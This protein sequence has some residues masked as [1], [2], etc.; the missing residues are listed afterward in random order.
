[1][2]NLLLCWALLAVADAGVGVIRKFNHITFINL[3]NR[4]RW[5]N[6][7]VYCCCPCR[8]MR[9]RTGGEDYLSRRCT[10]WAQ[11]Q[12]HGI[13]HG[14]VWCRS[15]FLIKRPNCN[16]KQLVCLQSEHKHPTVYNLFI[17]IFLNQAYI[18]FCIY[19][20]CIQIMFFNFSLSDTTCKSITYDSKISGPGS[21]ETQPFRPMKGNVLTTHASFATLV[22][23]A[24]RKLFNSKTV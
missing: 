1:M 19:Q 20:L 5:L 7:T 16:F 18:S 10:G 6:I 12:N 14:C 2:Q 8:E 11:V 15:V 17:Y 24:C 23:K 9:V 21:L 13:C 3:K 22:K 4:Q